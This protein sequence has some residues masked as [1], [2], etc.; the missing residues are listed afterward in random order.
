MAAWLFERGRALSSASE[1][2]PRRARLGAVVAYAVLVAW[3]VWQVVLNARDLAKVHASGLAVTRTAEWTQSQTLRRVVEIASDGVVR[4]NAAAMLYLLAGGDAVYQGLP[5]AN[6]VGPVMDGSTADSGP[7][8]LRG[9]TEGDLVVWF[10]DA[11][12][13]F[14]LFTLRLTPGLVLVAELADG[15][16][17]RVDKTNRNS[18]DSGERFLAEWAATV[19]TGERGPTPHRKY[20]SKDLEGLPAFD[21]Y[22]RDGVLSYAREPCAAS[23]VA[24]TFFLHI[25]PRDSADLPHWRAL[26]GFDNLDFHFRQAGAIFGGKCLAVV[27]L[28]PYPI[29]RVRTGQ[30]DYGGKRLW[31]VEFAIPTHRR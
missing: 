16:I 19:S 4:S 2:T 14:S 30:Y 18:G 7:A 17:F 23:D 11:P 21:V 25:V 1:R 22:W 20:P 6:R 15:A 8:H 12:S 26:Y 29:F 31:R 10:Q 5:A 24:A 13:D 3:A 9:L 27:R 28:P